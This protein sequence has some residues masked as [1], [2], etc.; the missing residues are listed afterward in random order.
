MLNLG[1]SR[2]KGRGSHQTRSPIKSISARQQDDSHQ[3]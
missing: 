2:P 1:S 3:R